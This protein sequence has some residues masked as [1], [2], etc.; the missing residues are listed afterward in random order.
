[1]AN[2]WTSALAAGVTALALSAVLA[3]VPARA[4]VA[5]HGHGGNCSDAAL[6]AIPINLVGNQ[7]VGACAGD[8]D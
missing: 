4:E 3:A 7:N 8:R 5:G 6:L 2:R 1:M